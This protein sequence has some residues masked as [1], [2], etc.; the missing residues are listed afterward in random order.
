[1]MMCDY[2]VSQDFIRGSKEKK[3]RKGKKNNITFVTETEEEKRGKSERRTL[4]TGTQRKVEL[5]EMRQDLHFKCVL[6]ATLPQLS[7][8]L[9]V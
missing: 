5:T 3:K 6:G 8:S 7:V 4:E 1:M 2:E 9:R